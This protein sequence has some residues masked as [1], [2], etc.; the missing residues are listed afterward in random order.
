[1]PDAPPMTDEEWKTLKRLSRAVVKRFKGCIPAK[2]DTDDLE[3][4]ALVAAWR[5]RDRW[6]ADGGR[7]LFSWQYRMAIRGVV[8]HLKKER[9]GGLTSS[10][11][12]RKKGTGKAAPPTTVNAPRSSYQ[13]DQ[14]AHREGLFDLIPSRERGST[15]DEDEATAFVIAAIHDL[16]ESLR[17]IM[18]AVYVH[19]HPQ[20]IVARLTG[21]TRQNIDQALNRGIRRLRARLGVIVD[22]RSRYAVGDVL[23]PGAYG[24]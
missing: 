4:A 24:G 17:W 1:M 2:V 16:P 11:R 10:G 19:G 9:T 7:S 5:S 6:R 14:G 13:S 3:E 18:Q 20:H 21:S 12:P 15:L 8:E 23:H 22:E